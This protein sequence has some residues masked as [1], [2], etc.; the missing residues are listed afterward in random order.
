[1]GT[2][3]VGELSEHLAASGLANCVEG[4]P[5]TVLTAVNTLEEAGPGEVSFLANL[6]YRDRLTTTKASAVLVD[7]TVKVPGRVAAIR[8]DDP[9]AALCMT[10]VKVHGYRRH[11]QWGVSDRA[12]SPSQLGSVW[13]PTSGPKPM[14]LKT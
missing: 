8:S 6:K 11:P 10:I 14:W 5:Q 9:Y 12:I 4:D 7:R 13:G 1:M 3:R 2:I